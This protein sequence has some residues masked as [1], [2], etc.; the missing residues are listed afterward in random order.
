MPWPRE[1]A[2]TISLAMAMISP[3]CDG[4]RRP[5]RLGPVRQHVQPPR[6]VTMFMMVTICGALLTAKFGPS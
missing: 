3:S 4:R 6:A 1:S 5:H 2:R